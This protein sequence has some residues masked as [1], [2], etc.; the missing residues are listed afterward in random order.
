M[1]VS[2]HSFVEAQTGAR[3]LKFLELFHSSLLS[4]M[5]QMPLVVPSYMRGH[6]ADPDSYEEDR[7]G[8]RHTQPKRV[9]TEN[10]KAQRRKL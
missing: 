9:R 1:V 4:Q 6:T 10:G 8:C 2:R 5:P 3:H 7:A